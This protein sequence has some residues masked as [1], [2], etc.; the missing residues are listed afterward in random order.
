M[1]HSTTTKTD[2]VSD[3]SDLGLEATFDSFAS[4]RLP[5]LS[6]SFQPEVSNS[7]GTRQCTIR[8]EIEAEEEGRSEKD[9]ENPFELETEEEQ[10]DDTEEGSDIS[11]G[12]DGDCQV[13]E[14]K[15]EPSQAQETTTSPLPSLCSPPR[16]DVTGRLLPSSPPPLLPF[17][18]PPSTP[19]HSPKSRF[20]SST[21]S[22][23]H[24]FSQRL[25]SGDE[26]TIHSSTGTYWDTTIEMDSFPSTPRSASFGSKS[27]PNSIPLPSPLPFPSSPGTSNVPNLTPLPRSHSPTPPKSP[28]RQPLATRRNSGFPSPFLRLEDT[29]TL[30]S[31]SSSLPSPSR[32]L[33]RIERSPSGYYR[34]PPSPSFS[35][36]EF[37]P[38]PII[39]ATSSHFPFP[40]TS[41]NPQT[42]ITPRLVTTNPFPQTP[43]TSTSYSFFPPHSQEQEPIPIP[44]FVSVFI[45]PTT[46]TTSLTK[47]KEIA[48]SPFV[49]MGTPTNP[50]FELYENETKHRR[51]STLRHRNVV[52]DT[53]GIGENNFDNG[54]GERSEGK[55]EK[56]LKNVSKEGEEERTF[57]SSS[58]SNG[59][60][61]A[62]RGGQRKEKATGKGK[63]KFKEVK[64]FAKTKRGKWISM[65]GVTLALLVLLGIIVGVVKRKKEDRRNCSSVGCSLDSTCITLGGNSIARAFLDLANVSSTIWNPPIDP[66]RLAYTLNHYVSP[67][68]FSSSTGSSSSCSSQLS[69]LAIPS[70]SSFPNH[71]QFSRLALVHTLALTES[72]STAFRLYNFICSLNFKTDEPSSSPNSNYQIISGGF[73]WDFSTMKRTVQNLKWKDLV[74]PREEEFDRLEARNSIEVLD[75]ISRFAVAENSQRSIALM[76]FWKDSLGRKEEELDSFRTVVRNSEKLIPFDQD[77]RTI[78][79]LVG[80]RND[81][82]DIIEGIGCRGDLSDEVQEKVN[83]VENKV[84]DLGE[85]ASIKSCSARPIYGVL[86]LFHLSTPFPPSLLSTRPTLPQNYLVLAQNVSN[87]IS[88]HAGETFS[89][90]PS[91]LPPPSSL[92]SPVSIE[93][94][95]LVNQLD[96]VLM[97]YLDLLEIET[98]NLVIDFLLSN[99][100]LPPSNSSALV[101]KTIAL[102]NLPIFE[103]Q[104]WGGVKWNDVKEVR[105]GI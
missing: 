61:I 5:D 105:T 36:H 104:I 3:S 68:P 78:R 23:K 37:P 2:R 12:G 91:A 67:S 88:L 54:S 30:L 66:A 63:I 28:M 27:K 93:R 39:S 8:E 64:R 85:T 42:P 98:A 15:R 99:S 52:L 72:N 25:K 45:D 94:S 10:E 6:F 48:V 82:L 7:P 44:K 74:K 81:S 77:V 56:W 22:F 70:L 21:K 1:D 29:P 53:V 92:S 59:D 46:S 35:T 11:E 38:P 50:D 62:T 100:I 90:G 32:S 40:P 73:T 55:V 20:G 60:L 9:F 51:T 14:A 71:L 102:A 79:G 86:N 87:R 34:L 43:S 18:I 95:G 80:A 47:E 57:S 26:D 83:E 103:I 89:A 41:P 65:V 75:R 58:A 96:H 49:S 17:D 76:N 101:S 33:Q 19:P 31:P 69:L 24:R 16:H 13:I 84:F 97:D 4:N